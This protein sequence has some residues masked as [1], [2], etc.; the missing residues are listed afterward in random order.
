MIIKW[1]IKHPTRNRKTFY[2]K[3]LSVGEGEEEND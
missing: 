1:I 3:N 2:L